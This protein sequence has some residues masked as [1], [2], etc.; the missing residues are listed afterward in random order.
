MRTAGFI[1]GGVG[2]AGLVVFAVTA[3]ILSGQNAA[4]AENCDSSK[5]CNRE[6]L[7]AANAGKSLTPLNAAGLIIGVAGVGLGATL[8]LLSPSPSK[9]A[10]GLHVTAGPGVASASFAGIF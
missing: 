10:A 1:S 7:D 8:I 4:V 9:P 2:V 5:R 3:G 6:G